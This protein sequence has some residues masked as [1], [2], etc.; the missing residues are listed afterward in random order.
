MKISKRDKG[1]IKGLPEE[2]V[3]VLER[4][5]FW[6]REIPKVRLSDPCSHCSGSSDCH[7]CGSC[8]REGDQ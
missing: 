4:Y 2:D 6:H 1:K 8:G 7:P 3:A 5:A